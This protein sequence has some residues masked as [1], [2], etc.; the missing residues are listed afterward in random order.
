MYWI[1]I[2]IQIRLMAKLMKNLKLQYEVVLEL[3]M[4]LIK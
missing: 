4:V 3:W 1:Q 2:Q